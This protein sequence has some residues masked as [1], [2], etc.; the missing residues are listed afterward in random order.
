MLFKIEI[1]WYG[2]YFPEKKFYIPWCC[3]TLIHMLHSEILASLNFN[4]NQNFFPWIGEQLFTEML[5]RQFSNITVYIRVVGK[6]QDQHFI[7]SLFSNPGDK[8]QKIWTATGQICPLLSTRFRTLSPGLKD[9]GALKFLFGIPSTKITYGI[10]LEN[11]WN[12]IS[13]YGCPRIQGTRF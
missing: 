4:K 9:N 11:C 5:F 2:V 3:L 7:V 8:V 10:M 12:N 13:M 1:V 6:I